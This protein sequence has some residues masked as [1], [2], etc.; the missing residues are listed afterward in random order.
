MKTDEGIYPVAL[1]ICGT[2]KQSPTFKQG[3]G[4]R[5]FLHIAHSGGFLFTNFRT[6]LVLGNWEALTISA[7]VNDLD[8]VGNWSYFGSGTVDNWKLWDWSLDPN[9]TCTSVK[10]IGDSYMTLS[11]KRVQIYFGAIL[12]LQRVCPCFLK[13]NIMLLWNGKRHG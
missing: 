5:V 7:R 11:R 13:L 9:I 6:P 3:F 1:G 8:A 2:A 12:F 4:E 10:Y